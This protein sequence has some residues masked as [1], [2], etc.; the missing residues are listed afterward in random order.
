MSLLKPTIDFHGPAA[1]HDMP[2][3]VL[4]EKHAVLDC[5]SGVFHPSWEAQKSGWRL[6]Q[7]KTWMQRL[8]L[9]IAFKPTVGQP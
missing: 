3:A 4:P 2:C 6:I 9:R 5:D 1:C 7:V 8:T